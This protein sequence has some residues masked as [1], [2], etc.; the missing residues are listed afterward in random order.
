[1][2]YVPIGILGGTFDP[3]HLGHLHLAEAVR[4]KLCLSSIKI[5]PCFQSP[6]RDLPSASADERARMIELALRDH[7]NLT[8]DTRE[9]YKTQKS[10]TVDMLTEI[11]TEITAQNQH[12]SLCLIMGLDAFSNFTSWKNWQQIA[13]LAHIIVA[14]RELSH[15]PTGQPNKNIHE[16]APE[17]LRANIITDPQLLKTQEAGYILPVNIAHL[18][19]SATQ[20]R[21]CYAQGKNIDARS[22]LPADV[23]KYIEEK[24][25]YQSS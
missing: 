7:P 15:L 12:V 8:L 3:I 25:L 4:K 17:I 24:K 2:P 23:W 18:P 19:I 5:I 21:R 20:I 16:V 10:Y 6:L 1:M 9:L 14:D 13:K 11:R 22:M